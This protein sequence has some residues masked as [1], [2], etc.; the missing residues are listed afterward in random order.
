MVIRCAEF[1]S[2]IGGMHYG[3]QGITGEEIEIVAAF[4]INQIA[5]TVYTHNFELKPITVNI[6]HL[7]IEYFERLKVDAW[8]LSPPCQPYTR[9]GNL[10]DDEDNR[11]AGLLHL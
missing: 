1:F 7:N 2:G 3:T 6:E 5:N 10:K 11:S 4:D 9:G 8:L